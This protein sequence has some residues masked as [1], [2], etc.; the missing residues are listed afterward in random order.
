MGTV[1]LKKLRSILQGNEKKSLAGLFMGT[2]ALALLETFSVGV[3]IPIMNLFVNQERI[4]NTGILKW[5]YQLMGARGNIS[6]LTR[7]IIIAS[8]LFIAKSLYSVFILYKQRRITS[9]IRV[10]VTKKLLMS[11]LNKPYQFHLENNSTLLFRNVTI[12]VSQFASNFLFSLVLICADA[13]IV[14]SIFGLLFYIY[15]IV[16]ALLSLILII[17]V[18]VINLFIKK[19]VKR[20][21]SERMEASEEVYRFGLEALQ[22]VKDI[23]VY[24]AQDYFTGRYGSSAKKYAD[25]F[26]R[27]H[28]ASNMPRYVL[29]T[30]LWTSLFV[31]LLVS[32]SY[33]ENPGQLIPM[34]S[35][36]AVAALRVLPSINRMY[37]QYNQARYYSNSVDI[38]YNAL[39][40][41]DSGKIKEES[42]LADKKAFQKPS[43]IS[44]KNI[45]FRYGRGPDPVFDEF[46]IVIPRYKTVAFAGETGAGKSTLIDI[47]MGLLVPERGGLCYGST[48]ITIE[49]V[50][51]YSSKISYVPQTIL[52]IDDTLEAN[53]AFGISRD[54]ID[55]KRIEEVVQIAQLDTFVDS[56][57][58]GIKTV[59]GEKG[60]RLSGGQRQRIAIARALY[61]NPEILIMDE[62]TSALDGYTE[63]EVNKA[64]KNLCGKLTIILIAHR[65]STI[66]YA[67]IIYVMDNGKI[68]DQGTFKELL[69]KSEAFRK[70]ANQITA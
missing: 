67:D 30:V 70:I 44:L 9:D 58:E 11:Y 51:Q 59:V 29:E 35:A 68:V 57:P 52:L 49:N 42:L 22:A 28:L 23:K 66:E 39:M 3:I 50:S 27:F 62:A 64:I 53:I 36:F 65:L 14:I 40:K 54:N 45:S 18:V 60:V 4:H 63:S 7:L 13:I 2:I 17:S 5:F 21:S 34:M 1:M 32:L 31:T 47:L 8:I 15:P 48:P 55:H 56:L 26:V 12:S 33:Y 6:F 38:V 19:R 16:T 10:R 37:L 25:N 20:Y 61:R 43:D 46:S 69:E 24:N 41:E